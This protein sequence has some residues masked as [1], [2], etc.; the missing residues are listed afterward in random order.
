[1]SRLTEIMENHENLDQLFALLR[2]YGVSAEFIT[3]SLLAE[4]Q[5][6]KD[7]SDDQAK[8]LLE[9]LNQFNARF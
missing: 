5:N 3:A 4:F 9:D 8:D 6:Q 7:D 2:H 1:M